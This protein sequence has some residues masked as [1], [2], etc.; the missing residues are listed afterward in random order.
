MQTIRISYFLERHTFSINFGPM[1]KSCCSCFDK[2]APLQC[3]VCKEALCKK[4][5]QFLS[6]DSFSFL[7]PKPSYLTSLVFCPQCYDSKIAQDLRLYEETIEKAKDILVFFKDQS[8]ETRLMSR[9]EPAIKIENCDDREETL[10][11]LA[12][13]AAQKNFNGLVDVE[14]DSKKVRDGSY[15][16]HKWSG[17]AVPTHID[18]KKINR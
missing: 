5:A 17:S 11:R 12:F 1:E 2:K 4:C 13:V 6:E 3:G 18:S 7:N 16:T 9:K 10:L 14:L 15:Q 8:K